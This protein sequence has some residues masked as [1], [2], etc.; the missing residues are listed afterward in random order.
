MCPCVAAKMTLLSSRRFFDDKTFRIDMPQVIFLSF[1][2]KMSEVAAAPFAIKW[3]VSLWPLSLPCCFSSVIVVVHLN[4]MFRFC[5]SAIETNPH[6]TNKC[7]TTSSDQSNHLSAPR[8]L[9]RSFVPGPFGRPKRVET[10]TIHGRGEPLQIHI[11]F[12]TPV[13]FMVALN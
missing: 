11:L 2:N 6:Q 5:H 10:S 13:R 4:R 7:E 8:C 12:M 9:S 1:A 3:E